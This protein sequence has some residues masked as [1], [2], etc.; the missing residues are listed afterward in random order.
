MKFIPLEQTSADPK[1]PLTLELIAAM[2]HRAFGPNIEIVEARELEGGTISQVWLL[3]LSDQQVILRVTPPSG[4][5][6]WDEKGLMRREEY[7]KPFFAAVA[8]LM[9]R[10]LM[11]DFTRQLL[12]QDYLLQ[13]FMPGE[14]WDKIQNEFS[15]AEKISLWEQ[16]GN[17]TKTI[18]ATT[19]SVFGGPYPMRS[20]TSWSQTVQYRL[21]HVAQSMTN[22]RLDTSALLNVAEIVATHSALLDEIKTPHLLHGD[23]WLFNLLVARTAD[24][25]QIT[26]V[27][28]TDRAWWG[29][30]MADWTMF[31][32]Q[33][34]TDPEMQPLFAAFWNAYGAPEQTPAAQFRRAVYQAMHIG[35]S[36]VW[37]NQHNDTETLERGAHDMQAAVTAVSNASTA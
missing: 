26:A 9:P 15:D 1:T 25:A 37:A 31:V 32:L 23:L 12:A 27:L 21:E 6:G 19:G 36:L 4:A 11:A 33:M 7:I 10:T 29:D 14:R 3:T 13:T 8:H 24:G 16:F 20:F 30:P 17:L 2:C 22:A 18:H 35:T 5:Y 34:N 28:D